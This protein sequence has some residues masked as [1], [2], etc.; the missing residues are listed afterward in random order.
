MVLFIQI[1]IGA[2]NGKYKVM[3]H[4]FHNITGFMSHRNTVMFDLVIENFPVGGTWVELGSWT[5]K[6]AAYCAVELIRANKLGPC[7]IVVKPECL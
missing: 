5:G 7:W 3:E 2:D 6:S 1:F 4:F